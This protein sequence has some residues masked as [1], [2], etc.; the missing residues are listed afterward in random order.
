[1]EKGEN[2]DVE[3]KDIEKK[4]VEKKDVEKKDVE[5][6]DVEKKDVEKKDIEKKK[7]E[8]V[9]KKNEKK[10]V[11]QNIIDE[12]VE[13]IE[14]L[15]ALE[16]AELSKKLE[17]KFG[18]QGMMAPVGAPAGIQQQV[19]E[20][21]KDEKTMFDIIMKNFGSNKIQAIKEVRAIT[22]L[23]LKEAKD[24]VESLPK[25]IKEKINKEEAEE[26]KKKL[27]GIGAEAEIK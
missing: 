3:K 4:D 21:K 18:V 10:E 25:P 13:K 19:S 27:E 12:V 9:E 7:V 26:I 20:E 14:N 2:K 6:K 11:G 5:K 22:T 17:E 16:L 15:S 8:K 1:M 23:G 24:L